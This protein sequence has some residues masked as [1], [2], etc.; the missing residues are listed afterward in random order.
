MFLISEKKASSKLNYDD[1]RDENAVLVKVNFNPFFEEKVNFETFI[2]IDRKRRA[3]SFMKLKLGR[4]NQNFADSI[5]IVISKENSTEKISK[6]SYLV[7]QEA[8][9]F[10]YFYG[11]ANIKA[12]GEL[13]FFA[14]NGKVHIDFVND[15]KV[16]GTLSVNLRNA[17]GKLIKLEGDFIALK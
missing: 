5:E 15:A 12:L 14:K 11:F 10:S 4:K 3:T 9:E 17:N 2:E 6:G 13:P 7:S 16:E 8:K 1:S